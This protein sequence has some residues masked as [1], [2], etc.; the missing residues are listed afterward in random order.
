MAT[1]IKVPE[2]GEGVESG[3]V[4]EVFVSVGDVIEKDADL[5]ELETDKATVAVPASAGGKIVK[6]HVAEGDTIAAGACVV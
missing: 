4:L 1:D 3:D 6:I 5:I 2:L